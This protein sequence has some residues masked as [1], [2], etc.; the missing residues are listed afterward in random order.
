[1]SEA[2]ASA[3]LITDFVDESLLSLRGLADHLQMFQQ[4]PSVEEPIHA[5][6]RAIHSI[7]GC[8]LLESF[9][10][11]TIFALARKYARRCARKISA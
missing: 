11:Q 5:V 9:G 2:I 8:G 6:F 1:M 7:K 10:N 4:Q 3:E